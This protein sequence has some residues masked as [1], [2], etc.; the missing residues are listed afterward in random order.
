MVSV[1]RVIIYSVGLLGGSL[2]AALKQSGFSGEIIG[3]SSP[4]GQDTAL[5]AGV[6]DRAVGYESLPTLLQENDLL[7]LCS[8]ITGII[9]ALEQLGQIDLPRGVIISDVGSTKSTIVSTART[10]L[11]SH[12]T[13]VG[14]HPMTGSEKSGPL[15]SDP[16][17]FE[18][19]LY[20]L[21]P[22]TPQEEEISDFLEVFLRTHTGAQISRFSPKTHDTIAA[23]ISHVPHIIAVGLVD[24]ARK[25]NY[26]VP[27]TL[28]LAAGGF[29]SVT[30]IA[31]SPYAMWRDIFATNK[32]AVCRILSQYCGILEEMRLEL[33]D[34]A[35]ED[36]FTTAKDVRARLRGDR[37]GFA[38]PL[39]EIQVVAADEPG[40][41]A[42]MTQVISA[43][44]I[45]IRDIEL[46]KV[47]EGEAGTFMLAFE[48]SR[49][50]HRAVAA[51]REA[52]FSARC[53]GE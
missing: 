20:V 2:G 41:L 18:N 39:H 26:E 6:I 37:K 11:P 50:A 13:F 3:V 4:R 15:H 34:D 10:V 17:L 38:A 8:P 49:E 12:V 27:G 53:V 7:F 21:T 51:L 16:L 32:R 46:L 25:I 28:S 29:K 45:N 44:H 14:G 52:S 40:F 36:R 24:L 30:R 33:M 19:A 47:R 22:E 35:L 5:K 23:T 48:S 43:A 42:R 9:A 31:S 1:Q